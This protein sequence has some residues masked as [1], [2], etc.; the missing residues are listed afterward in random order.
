M[1]SKAEA[2][3][4][5]VFEELKLHTDES[6]Y[7]NLYEVIEKLEQKNDVEKIAVS[8]TGKITEIFVEIA[9]KLSAENSFSPLHRKILNG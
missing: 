6:K 7:K 2:I 3:L 1:T 9:L 8:T 4:R 5:S